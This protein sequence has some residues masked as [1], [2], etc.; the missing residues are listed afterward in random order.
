MSTNQD[1]EI[2]VLPSANAS[3]RSLDS[4]DEAQVTET[5]RKHVLPAAEGVFYRVD[6]KVKRNSNQQPRSLVAYLLRK[7]IYLAEVVKV[8][9]QGNFK[10]K[11]LT[12]GYDASSETLQDEAEEEE[13]SYD[14]QGE[15]GGF[16][17]VVATPVPDIPSAKDAIEYLH[18]ISTN[19]G[20]K[21]KVLLGPEATVANYKSFLTSGIKGFVNVGHGFTGGIV[22]ADG[23]LEASWFNTVAFQA[24]K[25][26][27][28][29]LNSCQV[30]NDPLKSAVMQSG[31]RTYI[32]GIINLLIGS[33][34]EVCKCFWS[35][36][37]ANETPM[38]EA[39]VGCESEKY[40]VAG[41]HGICGDLAAF[42]AASPL[43]VV[44]SSED[45]IAAP[46][47]RRPNYLIVS[48]S[49]AKGAPVT[50]LGITNFKLDPMVVGPGG[51]LTKIIEVNSGRLPG[52]YHINVVPVN[53]ET[54]KKGVYIFALAVGKGLIRGQTLASVLM[55]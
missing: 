28:V 44:A 39:L 46:G 15:Y 33:S 27:V 17:L 41:A 16:D 12:W 22:L 40:P 25:P 32:G 4:S 42:I 52:F 31:S 13:E 19:L 21:C 10:V 50:N 24:V 55:D 29:Y 45:T 43:N 7:D 54:W 34:E 5:I 8:D 14:S 37:L 20:F 49:D 30:F 23:T 2:R 36:V 47:N 3:F 11:G 1:V 51:A 26:A 18:T 9:L 53:K 48:V 35:K 6:V 38:Q